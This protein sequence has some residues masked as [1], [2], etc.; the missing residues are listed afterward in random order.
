MSSLASAVARGCEQFE[1][2]TSLITSPR[3]KNGNRHEH[4]MTGAVPGS[5]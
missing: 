4:E 3:T 1:R 5:I 2:N